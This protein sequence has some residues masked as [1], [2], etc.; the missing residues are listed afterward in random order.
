MSRKIQV[1]L[2]SDNNN[3]HFTWTRVHINDNIWINSSYTK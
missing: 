1:S 2:K 3:E